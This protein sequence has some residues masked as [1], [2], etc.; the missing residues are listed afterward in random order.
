MSSKLPFLAKPLLT[1]PS[2]WTEL[3]IQDFVRRTVPASEVDFH[4]GRLFLNRKAVLHLAQ[5]VLDGRIDSRI[6]GDVDQARVI[7]GQMTSGAAKPGAY[8]TLG[9]ARDICRDI[10]EGREKGNASKARELLAYLNRNYP[11]P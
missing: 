9:T 5:A 8:L 4:S 7:I 6:V 1:Y 3:Q 11:K 10:I 2:D